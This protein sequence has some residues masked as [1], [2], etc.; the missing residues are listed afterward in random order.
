VVVRVES[1]REDGSFLDRA[2]TEARIRPPSQAR[3]STVA[4]LALAQVA[5]GR[6]E[7]SFLAPEA[8]VYTVEVVQRLPGG[9]ERHELAGV[10]VAADPEHAH[11]GANTALLGRLTHETGGR[12]LSLA[13]QVYA[14]DATMR[15][16]AAGERWD[17]LA[18]LLAALA[19]LLF[20]LD[21]AAR[22]LRLFG[23]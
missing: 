19:L 15:A 21:V 22:R 7:A 6:Y 10:A 5:P 11:A 1:L 9:P 2:P 23:A 3:G 18:P 17:S 8:G 12:L 14:R 4:Q 13:N 20:P 16:A